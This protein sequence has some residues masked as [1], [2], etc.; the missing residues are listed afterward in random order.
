MNDL[1][2]ALR[3]FLKSPGFTLVAVLALALGLGA[4]TA[5]FTV[6]DGVLLRPLPY[7]HPERIVMLDRLYQGNVIGGAMSA[8]KYR[9]WKEQSRSLE[10]AAAFDVFGSGVNLTG[11]GETERVASARVSSEFFRVLGVEPVL[12]RSFTEDED[13]PGGPCVAVITSR[14]W[15]QR[16]GSDIAIAGRAVTMNGEPCIIT[17]V[18][19]SSFRFRLNADIFTPMR[20][21]GMPRDH[22]NLLFMFG[23]LKPGVTLDAARAEMQTVFARF[24]M[25][26]ADL[27]ERGEVGIQVGSYLDRIV[28]DV[29]PSLWVLMGAVGLVLLIACANVANL[30]LSRATGRVKEMAVRTALGASRLRLAR[31]L[32][33]ENVVLALVGG[34]CGVLLAVWGVPVLLRFAP[35]DLPRSG[36]IAV[37]LRVITFSV[38]LSGLTGLIFG[39]APALRSSRIGPN[40]GSGRIRTRGLLI[41]AEVAL[42]LVLLAGAALLMRSFV[43][44]RNVSPGFDSHGVIAFRM[45]PG[46]DYST[47]AR[48]WDFERQALERI[49][50]IPGVEA[51][52]TGMSVPLEP[53][54]DFPTEILGRPERTIVEPKYLSVST[55]FFSLFGIPMV[56]GRMFSETDTTSSAPVAM[57]N[58]AMERQVFKDRNPLGERIRI[59]ALG[60]G[61]SDSPRVIVGVIADVRESRLDTPPD[62]AVFVPRSQV[63]NGLTDLANHVLPMSWVVRTNLPMSQASDA[64]RK[65]VMAVDARQPLS[66]MRTMDWVISSA[67]ARQQFNLL[68]MGVFAAIALLLAAVGIYGVVSYQVG[69]RARELG[70]RVALGATRGQ[71]LRVVVGQGLK[72][73]AAGLLVGL[74]ATLALTRLIQALLY[75]VSPRDP[76]TIA[77]ISAVLA[78]VACLACYVPARR[79]TKID[80]IAALRC[81]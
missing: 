68:L 9:F 12:G 59:D 6:V 22:D 8:A 48:L 69:Q 36:D 19:P 13:G 10:Y 81:E 50:A 38:L 61:L 51:A 73:I 46:P 29:R 80:P 76:W 4:N 17:G 33:A 15:H 18:L 67:V 28:G 49:R 79:A 47:T 26:N 24:A 78:A 70:I 62:M 30:L 77:A 7:P 41:A 65:A 5:I 14:L 37:D 31:Q 2:Y 20:V 64:V 55:G 25:A 45:S 39:F 52:A 53:W 42:S 16:F 44:L 63:P 1:R 21:A 35:G 58:Q 56:R 74:I 66:D 23:R 43:T 27:V 32:M 60:T 75:H 34:S 71:I 57:I 11:A 3:I 72:P 40:P 54:P